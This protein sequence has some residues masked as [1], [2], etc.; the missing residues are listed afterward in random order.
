MRD[1]ELYLDHHVWHFPH[2]MIHI[3]EPQPRGEATHPLHTT[4]MVHAVTGEIM[5]LAAAMSGEQ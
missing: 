2:W 3:S 1:A 4:V 5:D